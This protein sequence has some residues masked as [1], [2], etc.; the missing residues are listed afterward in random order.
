MPLD[1][2]EQHLLTIDEELTH[3]PPINLRGGSGS[4]GY[5]S[6]ARQTSAHTEWVQVDLGREFPIDEIVLVPCL[7]RSTESRIQADGFPQ[8]FR[9]IAGNDNDSEGKEIASFTEKDGLL[10]RI[11]PVVVPCS[12]T[13]ASWIR[14]E[15]NR[16]SKWGWNGQFILHL[17]ELLVFSGTENVALR[18]PITAPPNSSVPINPWGERFLT[19][20]FVPYLMDGSQDGKSNAWMSPLNASDTPALTIDLKSARTISRIHLHTIEL[21]DTIPQGGIDGFGVPKHLIIEASNEPDFSD[22]IVLVD[23]QPSSIFDIGPI[24]MWNVPETRCRFVRFTALS[25]YIY[26]DGINKGSRLGFAEIEVF[27]EGKNVAYGMPV[28][29]N[30]NTINVSRN[31]SALTDGHNF[32]GK[33]LP[34]RQWMQAL[35]QRHEL[36]KERP[37]VIA[38]LSHRYAHQRKILHQLSWLAAI[39]IAGI[40]FIIL[41]DRLIRLRQIADIKERLAADLHDELGANIH[42]IRMLSDLAQDTESPDE[43]KSTHQRILR[44]A[45]RTTKAIRYCTN[46][47]EGKGLYIGLVADMQRAANRIG[48][49]FEHTFSIEGEKWIEKLKPRESIDLF[50][51]YKEALINI[52]RH[53]GATQV[54]TQLCASNKEIQL[55]ITDNGK[56]HSGKIPPSLNRRARLIRADV[57]HDTPATGGTRITLRV[58]HK[59]LRFLN[60]FRW[61]KLK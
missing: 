37:L 6:N 54:S 57:V 34:I 12:N 47:L 23:Y 36:E 28:R 24:L 3:L 41:I 2:L 31:L 59:K 5:R 43:W 7:W 25:P 40:V 20:G 51:F 42:S 39:L 9:I 22:A 33:I 32:Y 1:A 58:S 15:V 35:A 16:L 11:A 48:G 38:E 55:T 13:S 4:I 52:C 56:G 30:Y 26:D 49:N 53:S 60:W 61:A 44:L 45:N 46:T 17:A 14:I 21:S 29:T 8:S 27:S 19:D 18:R 50:L 10:P